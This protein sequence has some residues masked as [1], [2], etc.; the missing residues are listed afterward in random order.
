[1]IDAPNT[2]EVKIGERIGLKIDPAA[3]RVLPREP[4]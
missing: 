4:Q 1:M 3:I 2:L